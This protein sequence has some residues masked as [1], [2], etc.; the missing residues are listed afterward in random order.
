MLRVW[1]GEKEGSIFNTSMFFDNRYEKKWITEDF[2]RTVIKDIDQSE[3]IDGN[4]IKSPVLGLIAPE[5]LSGGVKTLI[6]MNHY[7]RLYFNGS[8]C[9][10]NC[11]RWI[12]DIGKRKDCSMVLYHT[13]VFDTEPFDIRIMNE[14]GLIVHNMSEFMDASIQYLRGKKK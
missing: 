5:E 3:V 9:G 4:T 6:L 13:M 11:S 2:S 12:L 8:N 7:S 10:N 14:D 1:F